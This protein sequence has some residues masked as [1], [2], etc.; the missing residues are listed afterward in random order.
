MADLVRHFLRRERRH[1]DDRR[2]RSD[3]RVQEGFDRQLGRVGD[4]AA[5]DDSQ[6][7]SRSLAL[8]LPPANIRPVDRLQLERLGQR[9]RHV[10]DAPLP[11]AV[12]IAVAHRRPRIG[13]RD[14]LYRIDMDHRR[15]G[16]LCLLG[17]PRDG[18]VA[19]FVD[20]QFNQL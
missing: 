10:G 14:G 7:A 15:S 3:L 8:Q 20:R 11:D 4:V 19:P 2:F 12:Q 1:V 5:E 13:Q 16:S 6:F 18:N 9:E 17:L